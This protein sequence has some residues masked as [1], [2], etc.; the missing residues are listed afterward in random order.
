MQIAD[1]KIHFCINKLPV[2]LL[3]RLSECG[4]F[5]FNMSE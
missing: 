3:D 5:W 2:V 4:N 1:P